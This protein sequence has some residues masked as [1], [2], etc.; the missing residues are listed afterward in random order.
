M[1]LNYTKILCRCPRPVEVIRCVGMV[2]T[3]H[4]KTS[5]SWLR[6]MA[7]AMVGLGDVDAVVRVAGCWSLP[8]IGRARGTSS[9]FLKF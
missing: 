2:G 8:V 7:N 9:R 6:L 5:F 1:D 3:I 4:Y